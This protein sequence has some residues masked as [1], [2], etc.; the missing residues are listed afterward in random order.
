MV[1]TKNKRKIYEQKT[2]WSNYFELSK[3]EIKN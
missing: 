3:Y 1:F 2:A